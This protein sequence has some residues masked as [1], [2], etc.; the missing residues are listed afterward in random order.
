MSRDVCIITRS[1]RWQKVL[2]VD[3]THAAYDLPGAALAAPPTAGVLTI[4]NL[5][6]GGVEFFG[7]N[8]LRLIPYGVGADDSTFSML[9]VG[10]DRE[11]GGLWVPTPL[12]EWTACTLSTFAG[13][14]GGAVDATHFFCDL[15]TTTVGYPGVETVA[16][17]LEQPMH[18]DCPLS[19]F[20]LVQVLFA[21]GGSATAANALASTY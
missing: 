4:T 16:N 7:Q 3:D 12:A 11:A 15:A 18:M 1:N 13:M 19:G 10:W 20:A 17:A 14:A 6:P 2:A 8:K 5:L 9:V 21:L